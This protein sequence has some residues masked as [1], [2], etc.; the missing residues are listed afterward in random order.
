MQQHDNHHAKQAML[1]VAKECFFTKNCTSLVGRGDNLSP[2]RT[3]NIRKIFQKVKREGNR[4]QF[5]MC[6]SRSVQTRTHTLCG[7]CTSKKDVGRV[8][9]SFA[10]KRK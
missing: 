1:K 10:E 7:F 9:R 2:R 3:L 5:E 8:D 6:M 4:Q